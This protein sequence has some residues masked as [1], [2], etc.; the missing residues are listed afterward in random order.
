MGLRQWEERPLCVP[1]H[2]YLPSN[3]HGHTLGLKQKGAELAKWTG[4]RGAPN[5]LCEGA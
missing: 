4:W 3:P 2:R 1:I 5:P